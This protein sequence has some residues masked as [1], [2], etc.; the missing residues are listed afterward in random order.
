MTKETIR[1]IA[2]NWTFESLCEKKEE[3]A[4]QMYI[5]KKRKYLYNQEQQQQQKRIQIYSSKY[6]FLI[7]FLFCIDLKKNCFFFI[8]GYSNI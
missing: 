2:L 6:F 7:P 4:E 5:K 1:S 8:I 3:R